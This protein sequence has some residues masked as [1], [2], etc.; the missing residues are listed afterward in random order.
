MMPVAAAHLLAL[1]FIGAPGRAAADEPRQV[2]WTAATTPLTA[3]AK[4]F[5]LGTAAS[6]FGWATAIA[7]F[8]ADGRPDFA[9]ADRVGSFDSDFEYDV[10]V[11]LSRGPAQRLTL[12]APKE[13]IAVI[14]EDIDQDDDLDIVITPA[15]TGEV[16]TVWLNDGTGRFSR[17]APRIAAAYRPP[18]HIAGSAVAA[19]VDAALLSSRAVLGDPAVEPAVPGV[20]PIRGRMAPSDAYLLPPDVFSPLGP[21]APPPPL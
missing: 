3:A 2:E 14:V 17:A 11:E 21:R 16:L 13:A 5:R 10:D 6:P 12:L 18:A 1:T 8:D 20:R 15:L 4:G 7:D 19:A 9:I